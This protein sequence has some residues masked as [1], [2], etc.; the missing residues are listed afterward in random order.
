MAQV[1]SNF[2]L[3]DYSK[4]FVFLCGTSDLEGV[5][6]V[7]KR[8]SPCKTADAA[9]EGLVEMIRK[10]TVSNRVE[11]VQW[12]FKW[13]PSKIL[14]YLDTLTIHFSKKGWLEV[15]QW[16][17]DAVFGYVESN[18]PMLFEYACKEGHLP[19]VQWLH[20]DRVCGENKAQLLSLDAI[21]DNL[22]D[23]CARG[24]LRLAK[25]FMET[26]PSYVT[27]NKKVLALSGACENGHLNTAKL[28]LT[29][30]GDRS[31]L[32]YAE[33]DIFEFVCIN[34]YFKLAKWL[35]AQFTHPIRLSVE[36]RIHIFTII[37]N[38][39]HFK[40]AKWFYSKFT[41]VIQVQGESRGFSAACLNNQK[42]IIQWLFPLVS[43]GYFRPN[44]VSLLY[45][46]LRQKGSFTFAKK[47]LIDTANAK[48]A[49]GDIDG[50][51]ELFW[52]ICY[53][54]RIETAQMLYRECEEYIDFSRMN[55]ALFESACFEGTVQLVEMFVN[56]TPDIHFAV[57]QDVFLRL[58]SAQRYN[59]SG[60]L[61]WLYQRF[62][63]LDLD[64]YQNR[65]TIFEQVQEHN[66]RTTIM[67]WLIQIKPDLYTVTY[68]DDPDVPYYSMLFKIEYTDEYVYTEND[69][70]ICMICLCSTATVQTSCHHYYCETCVEKWFC[71]NETC[72]YCRQTSTSFS[73]IKL[74][75]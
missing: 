3:P 57:V 66:Y 61:K 47:L 72:P 62:P 12:L 69:S 55:Y 35:Y 43:L 27:N 15:L 54:E 65:H 8:I 58:F 64:I 50:L 2:K 24:H 33:K 51:H 16:I 30:I 70:E 4:L 39:G 59:T 71:K 14:D 20:S 48:I 63:Q 38:R 34:A 9:Y 17:F 46:S 74:Q 42:E 68:Y 22:Y 6:W 73:R 52:I 31:M 11:I 45:I 7:S 25:W 49:I 75:A 36:E 23:I 44:F 67:N 26:F 18:A 1:V 19:L 21:Y 60:I 13:S 28:L 29:Y 32:S 56:L 41:D 10:N 37:C 40:M 53:N 5:K